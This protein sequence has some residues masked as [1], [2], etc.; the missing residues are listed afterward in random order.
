VSIKELTPHEKKELQQVQQELAKI[1]HEMLNGMPQ[2]K[3]YTRAM[4]LDKINT[5]L[6]KNR[7][8]ND[9]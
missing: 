3:P 2:D 1:R 6:F 8:V 9:T 4:S 7:N 5:Q